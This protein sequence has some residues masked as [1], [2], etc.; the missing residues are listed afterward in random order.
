MTLRFTG[1]FL[2]ILALIWLICSWRFEKIFQ[3]IRNFGRRYI[4]E[5]LQQERTIK[6]ENDLIM[7]EKREKAKQSRVVIC[8]YCG[9]DNLL[10]SKTGKCMYCRRKIE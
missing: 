6:Q 10:S 7:Q 5:E 9:A 1:G 3:Q 8:P 2:L 4:K